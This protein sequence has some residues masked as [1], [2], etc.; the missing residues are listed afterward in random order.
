MSTT[1]FDQNDVFREGG[2]EQGKPSGMF[3]DL[4]RP[5]DEDDARRPAKK[6]GTLLPMVAGIGLVVIVCGFG[7]WKVVAPHLRSSQ[8]SDDLG[9]IGAPQIAQMAP[10]SAAP[11][12]GSAAPQQQ[13]SQQPTGQGYSGS[14]PPL[15]QTMPNSAP[16]NG[17]QLVGVAGA[18]ATVGMAVPAALASS[19]GVTAAAPGNPVSGSPA[20]AAAPQTGGIVDAGQ[21]QASPQS[22]QAANDP[23]IAKLSARVDAIEDNLKTISA[24]LEALKAKGGSE[25]VDKTASPSPSGSTQSDTRVARA[26]ER[27]HAI[28]KHRDAPKASASDATAQGDAGADNSMR[29]KAVLEGRA[30]IQTKAGDTVTVSTGDSVSPGVTVKSINADSGEVRLSNGTV[31]R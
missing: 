23:D 25:R 31:L 6:K 17:Q 10:T 5:E 29:L 11:A 24:Q 28:V 21:A 20:Q 3:N 16:Q 8:T 19:P 4:D 27:R 2:K 1:E 26:A 13:W 30:W 9:S 7:V 14:T 12:P 15:P 22:H 18:Q